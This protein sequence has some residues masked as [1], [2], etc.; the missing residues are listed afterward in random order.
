MLP[1]EVQALVAKVAFLLVAT[2]LLCMSK[3]RSEEISLKPAVTL[4]TQI[5]K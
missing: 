3:A 2:S 1:H 5:S 4:S